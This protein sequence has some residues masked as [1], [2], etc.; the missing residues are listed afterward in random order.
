[1]PYRAKTV[2]RI[3]LYKIKNF[4][5]SYKA[6]FVISYKAKVIIPYKTKTIKILPYKTKTIIKIII[7]MPPNVKAKKTKII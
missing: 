6:K 2:M 5:I 7:K 3:L 1:M 4:I